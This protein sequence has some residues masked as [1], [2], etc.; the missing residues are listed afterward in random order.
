MEAFR[1]AVIGLTSGTLIALV[2]LGVVVVYRSSGVL[3][4]AAGAT[5]AVGAE[6]C[7]HLRA[8]HG[9]S[10]FVVISIGVVVGALIGLMTQFLVMTVLRDSS[11]LAK[12]IATLGILSAVQGA[13]LLVWTGQPRLVT[14][15]LPTKLVH[16]AGPAGPTGLSIGQD[17]LIL[18]AGAILLALAMRVF[19][20]KSRFGLATSAIAENRRAASTI[21]CSARRIEMINFAIGGGLSALAAIFL[22][23][24]VGLTVVTLSLLV[25]PALAAALL[26]RFSSFTLTVAGALLIGALQSVL[27][28]YSHTAGVAR[29]GSLPRHHRRHRRRRQRSSGPR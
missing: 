29:L 8:D 16:I 18:A 10:W 13:A 2:A 21:G 4:F 23:P 5:G 19:Y 12:L 3:N 22:A 26:G 9:W 14:G 25:L 11:P 15:P 27:S 20:A 24:T 1:F 6:V 7:Y 17:R 28:R